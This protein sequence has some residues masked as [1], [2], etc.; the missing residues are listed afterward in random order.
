VL[1]EA[2]CI[3]GLG[4]IALRRSD[5][6][7]ARTHYQQALPLYHQAGSVLG[8]ANCITGLGDIALTRSDHD[9]ARG[10][11]EQALPL[12][13]AIPAPYS[14]GWT[15][16]RLARLDATGTERARHWRAAREAWASIG[17]DDLI[18]SIKAEFE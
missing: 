8:E 7:T 5:Y 17:R 12:Y 9:G 10:H 16:V 11:Y 2:L 15:L 18:E 3:T 4:D 14:I 6:D 13:Q 1:G